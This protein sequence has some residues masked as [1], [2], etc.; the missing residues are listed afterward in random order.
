MTQDYLNMI[1]WNKFRIFVINLCYLTLLISFGEKVSISE[2]VY[3]TWN[4]VNTSNNITFNIINDNNKEVYL[5]LDNN[6]RKNSLTKDYRYTYKIKNIKEIKGTKN[7]IHK[8]QLLNLIPNTIY[9]FRF[10]NDISGYSKEYHFQSLPGDNTSIEIVQGGDMDIKRNFSKLANDVITD[11][12]M[13]ILIGGDIAYADGSLIN[14]Y[15]WKTW[16][17]L[18]KKV[19]VRPNNRVIPIISAIGNHEVNLLK[20][21]I[22]YKQ[23]LSDKGLPFFVKTFG[24]HTVLFVLD[25]N[26]VYSHESQTKWL[27][28]QMKRYIKYPIKIAMYHIPIYPSHRSYYKSN[29]VNGRRYWEKIFNKYSLNIAFENHDH[30]LKRTYMIK[31]NKIVKSGGTIYLGDGC[32]G[33]VPRKINKN[34]F[35]IKKAKSIN[36]IWKV[37][38]NNKQNTINV[39]A[40]GKNKEILDYFEL[41]TINNKIITEML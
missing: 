24:N 21:Y 35:Y 2:Q 26:H 23:F 22:Y 3:L 13:A 30:T 14:V 41:E 16:F 40:I 4:Q 32:W 25:T 39:K 12:T 8:I 6:P 19:M 9:Y 15:K 10:G 38:L 7:F 37:N 28:K 36:N 27:E 31:N 17:N 33:V 29:S 34:A 1:N 11:K 18:M 20:E 5:L